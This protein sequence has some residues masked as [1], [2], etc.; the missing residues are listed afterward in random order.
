MRII[1]LDR[2]FTDTCNK[3]TFNLC[4]KADTCARE[5][6]EGLYPSRIIGL[7]AGRPCGIRERRKETRVEAFE[8]PM[9]SRPVAYI[10][11]GR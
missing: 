4:A 5:S 10:G 6:I 7:G 8:E 2:L 3:N 11:R 1:N 9:I